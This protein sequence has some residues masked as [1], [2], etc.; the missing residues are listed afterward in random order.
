VQLFSYI[1]EEEARSNIKIVNPPIKKTRRI[2]NN[3]NC[4]DSFLRGR[5]RGGCGTLV[6]QSAVMQAGAEVWRGQRGTLRGAL[7]SREFCNLVLTLLL[8][9]LLRLFHLFHF[10]LPQLSCLFN[11]FVFL[12]LSFHFLCSHSPLS[13][14][15]HSHSLLHPSVHSS[16]D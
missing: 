6:W 10:R 5:R 2:T 1:N 15:T 3:T 12:L 13:F 8:F 14:K 9:H 11:L 4:N 16:H 7:K